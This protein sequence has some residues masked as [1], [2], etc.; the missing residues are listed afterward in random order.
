MELHP[1]AL[2]IKALPRSASAA[3]LSPKAET[4]ELLRPALEELRQRLAEE[5]EQRLLGQQRL[6]QLLHSLHKDRQ[7]AASDPVAAMTEGAGWWD[8]AAGQLSALEDRLHSFAENLKALTTAHNALVVTVEGRANDAGLEDRQARTEATVAR[9]GEEVQRMAEDQL[10][11][12]H[13][14]ELAAQAKD[15]LRLQTAEVR[16]LLQ[17]WEQRFE[18]LRA[19]VEAEASFRIS[20]ETQRRMDS[21][22][23]LTSL[24]GDLGELQREFH[25]NTE[26]AQAAARSVTP[27]GGFLRRSSQRNEAFRELEMGGCLPGTVATPSSRPHAALPPPQPRDL[28]WQRSHQETGAGHAVTGES[29]PSKSLGSLGFSGLGFRV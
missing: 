28:R 17:R 24:L 27:R 9:L 16:S 19:H 29:F 21:E 7:A 13:S 26:N 2:V 11:L 6:E 22:K 8:M 25:L 3:V 10:M 12:R 20:G 15:Q 18:A 14:D 5:C 23:M 4:S 1:S